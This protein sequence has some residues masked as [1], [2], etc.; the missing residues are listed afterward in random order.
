MPSLSL[1][2]FEAGNCEMLE[3]RNLCNCI[4]VLSLVTFQLSPFLKFN[5]LSSLRKLMFSSITCI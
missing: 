3:V 5:E 1:K 2:S 4:C